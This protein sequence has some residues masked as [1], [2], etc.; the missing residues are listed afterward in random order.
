ML[1]YYD[2]AVSFAEF[3]DCIALAINISNCPC[4]CEGCSESYL[5]EDVGKELTIEVI[6]ELMTK[7]KDYGITLIGFMGGDNS[8]QDVIELTKYIKSKYNLKVG[9]YSGLDYIDLEL[10]NYLD[11]YK[12]G[13]FILPKGK[14]EEWHT[15]NCG[16]INFPWSNQKMYKKV[17]NKLVDI[18]ERFRQNP[19]S[20]LSR[21]IIK[22]K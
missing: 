18:T 7:Y 15:Y 8:H 11:Y 21:Y 4:K 6:N 12:I 1:K 19:L 22:E 17:D 9:M 20:Y 5:K 3:P 10:V 2:Y 14:E 16:P 13:R